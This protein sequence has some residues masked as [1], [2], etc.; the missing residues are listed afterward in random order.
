[1]KGED[2]HANIISDFRNEIRKSKK[3]MADMRRP[4]YGYA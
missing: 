1:M 3:W 2:G 4:Q